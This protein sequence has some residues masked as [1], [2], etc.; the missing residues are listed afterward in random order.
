VASLTPPDT[1]SLGTNRDRAHWWQSVWIRR[2]LLLIPLALVAAA[3]L[4]YFGQRPTDSIGVGSE[5]KLTVHAPTEARSGLV[6]AVSFRIDAIRDLKHATL[7]LDPGWADGY[8][9]NG[10]APQP[11]SQ[12][13]RDG[14]LLFGFG[15]LPAGRHLIFWISLQINP[16]TIGRRRQ[17]VWLYDGST[18]VT[19]V[20]RTITIF[21]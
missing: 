9:F 11:T 4:N 13:S 18:I 1:L 15:H 16:T 3:L 6:Y 14:R 19:R 21:P 12:E 10:L 5:A 8:T 2:V 7:V 20:K 17:D